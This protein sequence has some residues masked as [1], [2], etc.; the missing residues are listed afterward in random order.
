VHRHRDGGVALAFLGSDLGRHLARDLIG[1][2]G[3]YQVASR[4]PCTVALSAFIRS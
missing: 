4:K 1:E 3:L 2:C